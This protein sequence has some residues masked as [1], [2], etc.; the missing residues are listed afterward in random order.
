[1]VLPESGCFL[2]YCQ[3]RCYCLFHYYFLERFEADLPLALPVDFFPLAIVSEIAL[4]LEWPELEELEWVVV[5]FAPL[6]QDLLSQKKNRTSVFTLESGHFAVTSRSFL[7]LW[8]GS[9]GWWN[10]Q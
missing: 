8:K 10:V 7:R 1:M 3:L 4:V 9:L 2:L 5:E 6:A